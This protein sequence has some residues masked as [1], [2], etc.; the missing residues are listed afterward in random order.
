M[1]KTGVILINLNTLAYTRKCIG[2]L[3]KQN[4]S[5]DLTLIDQASEEK[6]I[7]DLFESIK[8]VWNNRGKLTI[9][10]NSINEPLN[11]V[12]NKFAQESSN[13]YLC[14]LNNDV[15]IPYNFIKDSESVFASE[16]NVGITVHSTNHPH[17]LANASKELNYKIPTNQKIKQGWDFTIRKS[18][19][20]S[21][22]EIFQIFYGD[23]FIFYKLLLKNRKIAYILNSP[24]LHFQGMSQGP[25]YRAKLPPRKDNFTDDTKAWNSTG[26]PHNHNPL[27][28]YTR[29]KPTLDLAKNYEKGIL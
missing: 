13:E 12:W 22:P 1:N 21:I 7:R 14:Y 26:W 10:Y 20:E 29:I 25:N 17:W 6:G 18:D 24:I 27:P 5:F 9:K 16:P 23:D 4:V 19:W 2:D 15:R 28:E 3:L 8:S 11:K